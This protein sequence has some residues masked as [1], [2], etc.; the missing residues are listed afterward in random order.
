[1]LT[2]RAVYSIIFHVIEFR[3][4]YKVYERNW[5]ALKNINL[6]VEKGEFAFLIGATGAGKSTLL[7]LIFMDEPPTSG[8]VIVLG[9][10]SADIRSK[11]IPHLRRKIGIVFQDFKLL[12]DRNCF[13]NVAFS[14]EVTGAP[15]KLIKKKVL[16]ALTQTRLSHKRNSYPFQLSG[17]EQQRVAIARAVVREPSILLADEPTGNIDPEGTTEVLELLR[18]I[19]AAGTSI[20]MATHSAETVRKYHYRVIRLD[21]GEIRHDGLFMERGT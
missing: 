19:N 15:K 8:E 5:A 2:P 14:L 16:Q 10:S 3:K 20:I 7:R 12:N 21:H 6:K 18:D 1:M 11:N 17:G 4:V 9:H 13:D